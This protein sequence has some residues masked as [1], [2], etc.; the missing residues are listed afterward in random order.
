MLRIDVVTSTERD[1]AITARFSGN[2][3][4]FFF[5]LLLLILLLL[6]IGFVSL[7]FA[8]RRISCLNGSSNRHLPFINSSI[9]SISLAFLTR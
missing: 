4:S 9:H 2:F 3:R 8:S 5:L 1:A 6:S 7:L